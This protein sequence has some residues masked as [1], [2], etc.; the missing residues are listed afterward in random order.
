M[1]LLLLHNPEAG[2]DEPPATAVVSALE[3][4]G[5]TVLTRDPGSDDWLAELTPGLGAVV[6]QRGVHRH[7]R[8]PGER[9]PHRKGLHSQTT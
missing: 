2:G 3:D 4:G 9:Q 8:H 5:H 1:R 6:E 7:P